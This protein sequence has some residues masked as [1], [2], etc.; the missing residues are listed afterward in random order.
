MNHIYRLVWSQ[1]VQRFV[2]APETARSKGKGASGKRSAVVLALCAA[3]GAGAWATPSGFSVTAGSGSVTQ[4]GSTTNVYQTST[5]LS[6]NWTSLNTNK[7]ET[8]NFFQPSAS[9]VAVNRILGNSGTEFF[10]RLNANGVV[11]LINPNGV[12]FGAGSQ[13][14]VGGLVASTLDVSDAALGTNS[15]IFSGNSVAGVSNAGSI[16]TANGG[17]VALLGASVSNTGSIVAQGG[18]VALGAGNNVTLSMNGSRLMGLQVNAN[19]LQALASNGGLIQAD[20]GQVLM[21]AGAKDS[22]IASVVNNKGVVQAQTLNNVGGVIELMAGMKAGT[23]NVGGKL[24][25]SAPKSGNG[26]RIET[27]AA[28]VK[29]GDDAQITTQAVAGKTGTW[30][31]DPSDF[32]IATLGGDMTGTKLSDLLRVTTST[33]TTEVQIQSSSGNIY[34]NDAV[35]WNSGNKLT[36]TA[37][38]NIY[39]NAPIDASQ[40]KG[41]SLALEYGQGAVNAGNTSNYFVNAPVSLYKGQNFTTKLGSDGKPTQYTVVTDAA[42]LQSIA[43]GDLASNYALGSDIDNKG[44]LFAPISSGS[45]SFNGTLAGLGHTVKNLKISQ[46]ST[47]NV[48]LIGHLG[49][50]GVV[51][52]LGVSGGANSTIN[53]GDTVGA[54]VGLNEGTVSNTYANLNV[55]SNS[56]NNV[57]GLVGTN[58]ST[59][60]ITNSYATGTVTGVDAVG[61]LVGT[62]AGVINNTY[63]TGTIKATGVSGHAGA[64]VG[65]VNTGSSLSSTW[66]QVGSNTSWD[67][68]YTWT[69]GNNGPVL[70][71]LMNHA[72]V[73]ANAS[74]LTYGQYN[75]SDVTKAN[76]SSTTNASILTSSDLSK[77]IYV[78]QDA[79]G[80]AQTGQVSQGVYTLTVGGLKNDTTQSGYIFHYQA[81]NLTV[82]AATVVV[83]NPGGNTSNAN[84]NTAITVSDKVYDKGT[85]ASV[86]NPGTA[87]VIYGNANGTTNNSTNYSATVPATATTAQSSPNFDGSSYSVSAAF[88]SPNVAVDAAGKPTTQTVNLTTTLSNTNNYKLDTTNSQS[89]AL[90]TI[91]PASVTLSGVSAAN[92]VYDTTTNAKITNNGTATVAFGDSSY[93]GGVVTPTPKDPNFTAYSLSDA[94][95]ASASNLVNT[96]NFKTILNL[97]G[98]DVNNYVLS[99]SSQTSA[100][101]NISKAMVTVSGVSAADK[102]YDKTTNASVT[103]GSATVQ[104]GDSGKADGSLAPAQS[105]TGTGMG[106]SVRGAFA[107]PEVG[108]NKTV[109]LSVA[110]DNPSVFGIS[111]KSQSQTLASITPVPQR[112]DSSQALQSVGVALAPTPVVTVAA[113][114]ANS[115][116]NNFVLASAENAEAEQAKPVM[117]QEVSFDPKLNLKSN[118]FGTKLPKMMSYE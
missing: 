71:G 90:A 39:L 61:G 79:T 43:N 17:G 52:D 21:S 100:S 51:R 10:G 107:T 12:M 118:R 45:T 74:N 116:A 6:A 85:G 42:G 83:G 53:G 54:L 82:N 70:Q 28:K 97:T 20:G 81:A 58:A 76:A 37:Q 72:V 92:K 30:L 5:N 115:S 35:S 110:L 68:T 41:G 77:L 16:N 34:I 105:F 13:V 38:N 98:A 117:L 29:V 65:Q 93:A 78:V 103:S 7:N 91:N 62:N 101:A 64:L 89:T 11:Y 73:S 88:A 86:S 2:T 55:T 19:Q 32:T 18:T 80:S 104:L 1:A 26:G 67:M 69:A 47:S 40:G 56:G 59:G 36:L 48:G 22:L 66:S 108:T 57:G 44:A 33:G 84:S 4:N 114:K 31:I 50:G 27:S 8:L 24:D 3:L 60:K 102:M 99:A 113:P 9:S 14:N 87:T 15:Q 23:V 25:A 49:Q 111:S 106:Y 112:S 109:G 95:F 46:N 63:A 94:Q 96:V 75:F